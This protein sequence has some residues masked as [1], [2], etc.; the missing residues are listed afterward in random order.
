MH[1]NYLRI[2]FISLLLLPL[3][4]KRAIKILEINQ[5]D[6]QFFNTPSARP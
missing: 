5:G 4:N 3:T 1:I 2:I 6:Y